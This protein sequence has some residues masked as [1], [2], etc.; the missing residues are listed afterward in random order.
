MWTKRVDKKMLILM[1]LHELHQNSPISEIRRA[2]L[3]EL[4]DDRLNQE[5]DGLQDSFGGGSF[6]WCLKQLEKLGLFRVVQ[7]DL[8][9]TVIVP[10]IKRIE[11][12]IQRGE[13]RSSLDHAGNKVIETN[14]EDSILEEIIEE[15]YDKIMDRA[16]EIK[17]NSKPPESYH[18]IRDFIA[19]IMANMTQDQKCNQIR[20]LLCMRLLLY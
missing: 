11:Q 17:Y 1:V 7:K 15:V 9:E 20:S 14:V 2:R 12:F 8:K 18:E 13:S 19:K 3:R 4:C 16:V 6:E 10:N 5:T